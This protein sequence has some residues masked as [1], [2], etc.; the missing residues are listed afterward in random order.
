MACNRVQLFPH[1]PFLVYFIM[2]LCTATFAMTLKR[3]KKYIGRAWAIVLSKAMGIGALYA[4][5]FFDQDCTQPLAMSVI[6]VFRTAI[7]NSS[8]GIK[9]SILMDAVP[10]ASRVRW[11][12]LESMTRMTWSGSAVLGGYL[13]DRFGYRYLLDHSHCV[14][15]IFNPISYLTYLLPKLRQSMI[16]KIQR[17][18]NR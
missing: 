14:F 16:M 11:N 2:P 15:C 10:K 13:V 5:V 9:R 4:M 6:F 7:M 8:T 3:L 18:R 1:S 12:S 17:Q